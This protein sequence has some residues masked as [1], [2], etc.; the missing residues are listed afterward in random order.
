MFSFGSSGKG[1]GAAAGGAGDKGD[2]LKEQ[3]RKWTSEIRSQMRDM[4]RQIRGE[5]LVG[6]SAR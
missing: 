4:D 6:R 5:C 2:S 1:A 3:T